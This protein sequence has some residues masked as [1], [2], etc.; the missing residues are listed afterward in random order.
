VR[1]L[2]TLMVAWALSPATT[3]LNAAFVAVVLF[4]AGADPHSPLFWLVPAVY[5]AAAVPYDVSALVTQRRKGLSSMTV[6]EAVVERLWP[7]RTGEAER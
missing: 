7:S 3:L 6:A 5:L 4:L 1:R 2:V